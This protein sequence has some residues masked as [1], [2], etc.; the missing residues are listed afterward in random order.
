M[1][2]LD[3]ALPP[4]LVFPRKCGLSLEGHGIHLAMASLGN[5]HRYRTWLP[6][7]PLWSLEVQ[8][9]RKRQPH[10]HPGRLLGI[11]CTLARMKSDCSDHP[12]PRAASG[13]WMNDASSSDSSLRLLP[14]QPSFDPAIPFAG[15][16]AYVSGDVSYNHAFDM[17]YKHLNDDVMMPSHASTRTAPAAWPACQA[18]PAS[19]AR[20]THL[21]CM[22]QPATVARH[23][24][25]CNCCP[26]LA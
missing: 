7:A 1:L 16:R 22:S 3:P 17:D 20:A 15:T 19:P 5:P 23:A 8:M 12:R 24:R 13:P 10:R 21:F 2:E 6:Q 14:S 26:Q 4:F 9:A 25:P 11:R 18:C